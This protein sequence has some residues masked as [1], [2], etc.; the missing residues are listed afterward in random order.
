M[1]SISR[2]QSQ[3][4]ARGI[5]GAPQISGDG[6]TVVWNQNVDGNVD[7][8]RYK[9]GRV[10]RISQDPRQEIHPSVNHDGSVISWSRF[11]TLDGNDPEGNFDIVRWDESTGQVTA[12]AEGRADQ[13]DS[14]VS[15]DG[16]RVA[17]TTDLNGKQQVFAIELWENGKT[18]LLSEAD[19]MNMFPVFG[20]D[21][22]RMIWRSYRDQG[23]DLVM[24]DQ[25]GVVKPITYDDREEVRPSMT[26]DG[27]SVY[28]H[29]ASEEGDDDLY[30][31]DLEPHQLETVSEVKLVDES[32]PV[33]SA[34]G[35]AVAWTNF[36]RRGQG[37]YAETHVYLQQA[38]QS[39]PI[40]EGPGMHTNVSMADTPDRMAYLWMDPD[41]M[42]QREIRLLQQVR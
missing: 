13:T 3:T 22:G 42:D 38:G 37:E 24:R 31:V 25:D 16:K 41:A 5:V 40:T 26:A 17:W 10:D 29:A 32:W 34:D 33:T 20:G 35:S 8:F 14:V 30:R 39:L 15:P 9:D 4:I 19:G 23:S 12:L 28:F 27:K 7:I 1:N 36:D 21:S 18:Q 2:Y 6:S 11:S